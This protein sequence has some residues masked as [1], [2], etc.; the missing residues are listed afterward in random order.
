MT[1]YLYDIRT[2]E[3]KG[4]IDNCNY[5]TYPL[6]YTDIAP[7]E[8]GEYEIPVF[9]QRKKQWIIYPD[10]RGV[11]HNKQTKEKV[12]ITRIGDII[13]LNEYTNKPC[14][15]PEFYY[16]DEEKQDWIFDLNK[17][18]EFAIKQVLEKYI[19]FI[20]KTIP[21]I[22]LLGFTVAALMSKILLDSKSD[23]TE[24]QSL[25]LAQIVD[26]SINLLNWTNQVT[27]YEDDIEK[28]I[29]NA[30]SQD[31]I[32]NI[33]HSI[34]FEQFLSKLPDTTIVPKLKYIQTFLV[35]DNAEETQ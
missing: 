23:L 31:E 32:D 16:W 22:K 3:Y 25:N 15:N 11:W 1:C 19:Q 17:Y 2:G 14:P 21:E 20:S 18:K 30:T 10:Y 9:D 29:L 28:Q 34:N 27:I 13:D 8:F 5:V 6:G 7:P 35:D 12:I 24:D 33:I 26:D 4:K